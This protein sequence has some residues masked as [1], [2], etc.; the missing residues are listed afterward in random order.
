MADQQQ[1]LAVTAVREVLLQCNN[2]QLAQ[3]PRKNLLTS[4]SV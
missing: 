1:R 4:S 3:T 2:S